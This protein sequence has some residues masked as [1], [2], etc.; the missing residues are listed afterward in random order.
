MKYLST[1]QYMEYATYSREYDEFNDTGEPYGVHFWDGDQIVD[2]F[3]FATEEE[4]EQMIDE[5]NSFN[6]GV[7]NG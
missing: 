7:T 1:E 2:T 6:P 5:F 3:W 4:S